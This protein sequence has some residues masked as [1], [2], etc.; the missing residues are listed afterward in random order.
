MEPGAEL[1]KKKKRGSSVT[2]PLQQVVYHVVN[3]QVLV[4]MLCHHH[5]VFT[6]Q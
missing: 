5:S 3:I 1:D 6:S 2:F 4:N